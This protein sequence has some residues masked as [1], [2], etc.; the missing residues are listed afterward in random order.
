M[1]APEPLIICFKT[2]QNTLFSV[3]HPQNKGLGPTCDPSGPDLACGQGGGGP[4]K[5]RVGRGAA[6]RRSGCEWGARTI[7]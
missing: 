4:G 5:E 6:R 1:V 7:P 3:Q 2:L